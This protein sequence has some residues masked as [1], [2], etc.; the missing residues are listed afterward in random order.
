[1]Q[2]IHSSYYHNFEMSSPS[3]KQSQP[4]SINLQQHDASQSSMTRSAIKKALQRQKKAEREAKATIQ[5]AQEAQLQVPITITASSASTTNKIDEASM[6]KE[7]RATLPFVAGAWV[8]KAKETHA[9]YIIACNKMEEEKKR[10]QEEEDRLKKIE[11]EKK[12]QKDKEAAIMIEHALMARRLA[13]SKRHEKEVEEKACMEAYSTLF[14][15]IGAVNGYQIKTKNEYKAEHRWL[16]SPLYVTEE[17]TFNETVDLFQ[18]ILIKIA[19]A[20][21]YERIQFARWRLQT[22]Q[23]TPLSD[24]YFY[25]LSKAEIRSHAIK[26]TLKWQDLWN[27]YLKQIETEQFGNK[28]FDTQVSVH[29]RKIHSDTE[30]AEE[31]IETVENDDNYDNALILAQ[32]VEE[33]KRK[34]MLIKERIHRAAL[35]E[36]AYMIFSRLRRMIFLQIRPRFDGRKG[37][38]YDYICQHVKRIWATLPLLLDFCDLDTMP[39]VHVTIPLY[40]RDQIKKLKDD[41]KW[42]TTILRMFPVY[43]SVSTV[44]I[45]NIELHDIRAAPLKCAALNSSSDVTVN[46]STITASAGTTAYPINTKNDC[47]TLD[48]EFMDLREHILSQI[49]QIPQTLP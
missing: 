8:H 47:K 49:P 13:E 9:N 24:H 26:H 25:D 35:C 18:G 30:Y 41:K 10:K 36:E 21:R 44:H 11:L 14:K 2:Q 20:S 34:E 33:K 22:K 16:P 48:M 42:F 45:N 37:L 28:K 29:K 3:L 27:L 46:T 6:I 32:Q 17:K 31:I 5:E 1:M 7:M 43:G 40:K 15:K 12:A 19:K 4:I 38:S 23:D 39:G